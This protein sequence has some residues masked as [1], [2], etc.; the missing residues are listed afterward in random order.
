MN[1][2]NR[3][4]L[5][6]RTGVKAAVFCL[7][8][9]MLLL[10]IG[11]IFLA[12][13][14][15]QAEAYTKPETVYKQ[16]ILQQGHAG[17]AYWLLDGLVTLS[18]HLRYAIYI[19]GLV[20]LAA[21]L[22]GMAFLLS[23]AGKRAGRAEA[24][25]GWGAWFPLDLLTVCVVLACYLL[26]PR[27]YPY[28]YLW[29]MAAAWLLAGTGMGILLLG[30]GM[31]LSCR[32]KCGK[33]WRGMLV[34]RIGRL[35]GLAGKRLAH[36]AV[37]LFKALPQVWQAALAF[38]GLSLIELLVLLARPHV[39]LLSILFLLEKLVLLAILVYLLLSAKALAKGGEAL[40]NG[41]LT[42]QLKTDRMPA[43][44]RQHGE[45]LNRIC[46]GIN[47]AVEERM[48]SER[49]KTELITNVSHDIKTPLTSVINYADLIAR[50]PN[51]DP[52]VAEYAAVLL[53]Q[54]ERLKRLIDDLIE[55][56][57]AQAGSLEI[58]PA[59]CELGIL[60]TQV[61]AEYE[62]KLSSHA[63]TLLT[64]QPAQPVT[65]MADGRRMWRILDNLMSN[66]AKYAMPST[67]VYLS[68]VVENEHALITLKNTSREPLDI[69]PEELMERFT[70][71]DASRHTEGNGLGLAIARSLT[72]LQGGHMALTTD[73]D[74]FKVTLSFP[75]AEVEAASR[76]EE[77][78]KK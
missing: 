49:M 28:R 24:T 61:I 33:W 63:L 38:A 45:N 60:L 46:K 69:P 22:T 67:R 77:T 62:E 47:V 34:W 36:H 11:S 75:T 12:A 7:S 2:K 23:A 26:L 21:L 35:L 42:Y 53:R 70:R 64:K 48:R 74:F 37:C 6:C 39:V 9:V 73:G 19:I 55:A 54:S 5:S 18:Y 76:N 25:P 41:E 3:T 14:L 29:E 30:Y 8:I 10:L 72:E 17:S 27:T 66:A 1:T 57:K 58:L 40:A 16:E 50:E 65:I 68:L 31:S 20:A 44:L 56:S 15:L 78:N 32:L 13:W 52:K 71:G 4:P 51:A 59:P 43:P